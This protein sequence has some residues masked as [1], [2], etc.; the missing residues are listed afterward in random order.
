MGDA[1]GR[2]EAL[3]VV[4][5]TIVKIARQQGTARSERMGGNSLIHFVDSPA[6][7]TKDDA[8][9]NIKIW[10]NQLLKKWLDNVPLLTY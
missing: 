7:R 1:F 4:R 5:E 3:A 8:L 9:E 10:S 6:F 2:D